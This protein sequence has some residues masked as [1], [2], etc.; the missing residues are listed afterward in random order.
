M[1][2]MDAVTNSPVSVQVELDFDCSV[3]LESINNLHGRWSKNAQ[4]LQSVTFPDEALFKSDT[5]TEW[6][7]QNKIKIGY[8]KG[9]SAA[10]FKNLQ[11]EIHKRILFADGLLSQD[12]INLLAELWEEG[13]VRPDAG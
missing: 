1:L 3:V 13:I 8:F 6:A 10:V 11:A 7:K 9:K 5:I 2:V 4:N 12:K